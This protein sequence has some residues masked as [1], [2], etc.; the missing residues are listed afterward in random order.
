M[1]SACKT[2]PSPSICT[3]PNPKLPCPSRPAYNPPPLAAV[4]WSVHCFPRPQKD[5]LH[6]NHLPPHPPHPTRALLR[7]THCTLNQARLLLVHPV[8]SREAGLC[9]AL[10]PVIVSP[11]CKAVAPSC[12][13]VFS[14]EFYSGTVPGSFPQVHTTD[15]GDT[16]SPGHGRPGFAVS[17]EVFLRARLSCLS[18][19]STVAS[20]RAACLVW[21]ML[22]E[23]VCFGSLKC[24]ELLR[25]SV[26]CK[27]EFM[28]AVWLKRESASVSGFKSLTRRV[29]CMKSSV[30]V[31]HEWLT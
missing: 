9:D 13:Q 8:W 12:G 16:G 2:L 7:W 5:P 30:Q 17:D 15:G 29:S 23:N 19:L 20:F 1:H 26:L 11:K 4:L 14:W 6:A 27:N 10:T 25:E 24:F 22:L 31:K 21:T 18:C 3:P 28:C